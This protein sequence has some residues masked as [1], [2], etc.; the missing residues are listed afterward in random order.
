MTQWKKWT[1]HEDKLLKDL[2]LHGL[3]DAEIKRKSLPDRTTQALQQRRHHLGLTRWRKKPQSRG[4][5]VPRSSDLEITQRTLKA[6]GY[7]LALVK[8]TN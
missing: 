1:K 3:G 8:I 4:G 2:F 7:K 5:A 6:L